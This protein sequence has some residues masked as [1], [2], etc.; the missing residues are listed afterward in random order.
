MLETSSGMSPSIDRSSRQLLSALAIKMAFSLV[1]FSAISAMSSTE[2]K[3]SCL[4]EFRSLFCR[5]NCT[6]WVTCASMSHWSFQMTRKNMRL[7]TVPVDSG[8]RGWIHKQIHVEKL[9]SE[10]K[11]F[12]SMWDMSYLHFYLG[13][14]SR[15]LFQRRNP[16]LWHPPKVSN[17][18]LARLNAKKRRGSVSWT[19]EKSKI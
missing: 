6:R 18:G 14:E 10:R 2:G 3:R 17:D 13:I 15:T 16:E 11:L 5:R 12:Y 19:Q 1:S 7:S 8:F 4:P 9:I